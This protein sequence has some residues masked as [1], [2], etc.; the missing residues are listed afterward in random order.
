M[1]LR[2]FCS[3]ALLWFAA[4]GIYAQVSEPGAPKPGMARYSDRT[5]HSIYGLE[6]NLLVN[7]Q[8]LSEADAISFSDAGGLVSIA[9]RIQLL[10]SS[11][12]V[13][14]EYDSAERSPVLNI[15][16]DLTTAVAWLPSRSSIAHW[17]GQSFVTAEVASGGLPG[18]V[19]SVQILNG[20]TAKLLASDAAGNVFAVLVSLGTGQITSVNVLPGIKGPAFQQYSFVVSADGSGLH[21]EAPNGAIRTL[22]LG[23]ANVTFERMSSDWV[24]VSSAATGQDWALHLNATALHLSQLPV[25]RESRHLVARPVRPAEVAR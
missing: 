21:I 23:A 6:S 1:K 24:H 25:P 7:H 11:G 16:G 5:V 18:K 10:N 14:G 8:L 20:T 17:N 4:P 2:I 19:T 12:A 15:D 13:V 22:P 9:G 3:I